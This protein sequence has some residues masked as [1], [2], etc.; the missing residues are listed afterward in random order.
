MTQG[1]ASVAIESSTNKLLTSL[2]FNNG[3]TRLNADT[4]YV[5]YPALGIRIKST[6]TSSIIDELLYSILG[7]TPDSFGWEVRVNPT[8]TGT[9]NYI[10]QVGAPVEVAY[11]DQNNEAVDGVIIASGYSY[12]K[13]DFNVT[14]KDA[15]KLGVAINGDADEFVLCVTPITNG[16]DIYTA[17]T[18]KTN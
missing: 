14:V 18:I 8:I 16:L 7:T 6:H 10:D 5:C 17:A 11:G 15:I 1:S 4:R 2:S 3:S 13:R 12:N 9:F